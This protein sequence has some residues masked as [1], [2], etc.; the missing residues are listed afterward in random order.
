MSK[1]GRTPVLFH[2]TNSLRR[3]LVCSA[4]IANFYMKT[5]K[6]TIKEPKNTIIHLF[7]HSKVFK[8]FQNISYCQQKMRL[9]TL[10]SDNSYDF[11]ALKEKC[12]VPQ[13]VVSR[14]FS[15]LYERKQKQLNEF[16]KPRLWNRSKAMIL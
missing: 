10:F 6:L 8:I 11:Y 14:A 4:E 12:V 7:Q 2:F 9:R 1:I 5:H 16:L 15:N 13:D 3:W